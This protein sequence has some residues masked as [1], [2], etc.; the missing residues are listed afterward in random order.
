[1]VTK[2]KDHGRDERLDQLG[3]E[4]VLASAANE[5]E[6]E[7][8]ASS[9][10]LYTRLHS[11]IQQERQRREERESWLSM[12]AVVWRTVPAMTLVAIFAF[13]LFLSADTGSTPGSISDEALLGE[14][15]MGI[16]QVV[17]ADSQP[18]SS[19]EVLATI[20]GED[21]QGASR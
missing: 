9:P 5:A 16:E 19:D 1:M 7:V 2:K 4:I 3:R 18:L 14:R 15:D 13:V 12:L 21:E 10:F 8:V 11:R 20:L 17:F 6:A